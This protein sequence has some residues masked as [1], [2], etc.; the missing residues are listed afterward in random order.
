MAVAAPVG[1]VG[2]NALAV[3]PALERE[4]HRSVIPDVRTVTMPGQPE[5]FPAA[6]PKVIP[7]PAPAVKQSAP[8]AQPARRPQSARNAAQQTALDFLSAPPAQRK[9]RDEVPAQ[10]DCEQAVAAPMHRFVASSI[11]AAFIMIG[12]GLFVA[13]SQLMGS[14]FGTGKLFWVFVGACF[15]LVAGFYGLIFAIAGRETAGMRSTDL[16]LITF[17]GLPVEG[18]A[19]AARLAATWLSFCSGGLGLI[20]AL[21][22]EENLTWQDHISKTFPAVKSG[23]AGTVRR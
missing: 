9:L 12:F 22:D 1:Y 2:A 13:I 14:G 18:R 6:A 17:D 8:A 10:V 19:R 5:L 15:T 21:A 20:W 4:A 23:S 16:Q 7:F 3:A 11:D